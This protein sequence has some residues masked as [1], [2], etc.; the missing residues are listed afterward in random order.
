[1]RI[2]SNIFLFFP[3]CRLPQLIEIVGKIN[4]AS[5]ACVHEFSRFFWRLCRTFGKIFTNTKVRQYLKCYV[6][7][8]MVCLSTHILCDICI[9]VPYR[10]FSISTVK[11]DVFKPSCASFCTV[12]RKMRDHSNSDDFSFLPFEQHCVHCLYFTLHFVANFERNIPCQKYF[13]HVNT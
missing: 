1:M 11:P 5:T 4:V 9:Y 8:F 12:M 7:N 10:C 2:V 13:P 6:L 3:L